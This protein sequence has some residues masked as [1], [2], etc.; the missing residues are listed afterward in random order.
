MILS[1]VCHAQKTN[2]IINAKEV[3]RIETV[4]SSDDMRGRAINT[5]GIE[6]AAD[7]ISN[8]FKK[9]GLQKFEGLNEYS[10]SFYMLKPKQQSLTAIS[11]GANVSEKNILVVT[12]KKNF[13]IS[14]VL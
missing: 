2:K 8:E 13:N 11:D 6:K 1:V 14:F 3:K 10:Q 5:T 7:F 9:T 4:L 12:T